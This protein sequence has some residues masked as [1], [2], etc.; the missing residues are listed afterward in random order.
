MARI[1]FLCLSEIVYMIE[2]AQHALLQPAGL[3]LDDLNRALSRLLD[4]PVDFGDLYF[5]NRQSE[6]WSLEDGIVK[7]GSF[8]IDQGV[9][10]RATAG[11]GTGFAYADAITMPAL[12]HAAGQARAIART[13]E[14]QMPI[15]VEAVEAPALYRADNPIE[16]ADSAAK[17]DVLRMIDA[18]ARS[19]D[20][21]IRQVNASLSCQHESVLIAASDGTLAG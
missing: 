16:A 17:V 14:G 13:G 15:A 9:G 3:G 20:P 21:R 1:S 11:A 19:L 5:Q 4:G 18:Y 2:H 6:G 12:L 8:S 10:V 7:S